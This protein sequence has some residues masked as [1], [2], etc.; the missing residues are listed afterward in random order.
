MWIVSVQ[1]RAQNCKGKS[2][3]KLAGLIKKNP[4][5]RR[6]WYGDKWEVDLQDFSRKQL[7]ATQQAGG[8]EKEL[9]DFTYNWLSL[10]NCARF[11][12]NDGVS[13]YVS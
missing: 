13:S 6:S 9:D 7:L 10:M 2:R 1:C 12:G 5:R 3:I 4:D 8:R 11:G